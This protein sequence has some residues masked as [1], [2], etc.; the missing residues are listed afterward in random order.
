MSGRRDRASAVTALLLG[1]TLVFSGCSADAS[2]QPSATA[3]ASSSSSPSASA[4]LPA[5]QPKV[6]SFFNRSLYSLDEATSLWV[7]VNKLRPLAPIDYVPELVTAPVPYI[8]SP[9][10]RQPAA[11]AM[12]QMFAAGAAEGAGAMQ[13]QNAYRSFTT[14]TNVHQRYVTSLGVTKARA[15][16]AQ[17][18]YS[19]HQTGL[20]A[21]ITTSPE[22]CSIQACFGE[23]SQ[24]IWL[25]ANSWR[26]GYILR[27][28]A[29]KTPVT[30]YIY[31]P[32]H[33]RYVGVELSTEMHEKGITTLE[34]FFALPAAPDYAP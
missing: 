10:M 8:S 33:F 13:I 12:A 11:E 23:T 18:G 27:Y 15:Q 14:Q 25:A 28:P 17:P 32:W 7:V 30:G 24:G 19:E 1:A 3:E 26:F 5:P 9:Q 34:E 22:Q 4:A 29:D 21:D 16:S 20:T 31:E 2:P 6:K